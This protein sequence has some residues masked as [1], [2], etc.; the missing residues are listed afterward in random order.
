VSNEL[1]DGGITS[2]FLADRDPGDQQDCAQRDQ[3]DRVEPPLSDAKVRR[4]SDLWRPP[5][6]QVNAIVGVREFT[7][8]NIALIG[9][10]ETSGERTDSITSGTSEMLRHL[11]SVF[12]LYY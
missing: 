3:P 9:H 5:R 11:M 8:E 7:F 6:V 10:M 4:D 2:K 12:D 1:L